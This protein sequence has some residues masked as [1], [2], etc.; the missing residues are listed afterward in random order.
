[1]KTTT[2]NH[3]AAA[4]FALLFSALS[5]PGAYS[6]GAYNALAA[7]AARASVP[8]P[9]PARA[10]GGPADH[11]KSFI[12]RDSVIITQQSA[13]ALAAASPDQRLQ[14]L[15]TLM[16]D[17]HP[18][19]NDPRHADRA[20]Q[21]VEQAILR[22]LAA[23]PDAASFDYVYYRVDHNQLDCSVTWRKDVENLVKKYSATAV[24]GDWAGLDRY[25]D[26]VTKAADSGRNLI[27]FLIDGKE[28][29]PVAKE[30]LEGAQSSIH[31][32]MYQLQADNIGQG[33]ADLLS[34]KAKA[35]LKVRLL[36]DRQGSSVNNDPAIVTML[37]GMQ[38]NGVSVIVKKQSFMNAHLDHRKI[39]VID[40][41]VGFTGGMNIG[42][43]YQVDW[44]DQQTLIKGPAVAR[45]QEAFMERWNTAGGGFGAGEDL[46]PPLVSYPDGYNTRV[47]GH[48]GHSD[49][50]LK[51]M[52]LR[53][54]STAQTSISIANPYLTDEDVIGALRA[55]ADRGVKV[56]L[57]LPQDND[58]PIVQHASRASYPK[59]VKAGVQVYE[60][61]GRMAHEKVAVFDGRWSTFGSSN[62]DERSLKNNDE[63]NLV[64]SDVRI[65]Q[66]IELRLFAADLPNC[67]LMN[68]YSPD[69]L[70]HMAQQVSSQL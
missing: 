61:K 18:G 58:I 57:V 48:I 7:G 17:S 65:G 53:A 60:Y 56:R 2:T 15:K 25:I 36:I 6:Q 21:E 29:I 16:N 10:A 68:T 69:V 5:V 41:K 22:V 67:E 20:Q 34:A 59:L 9:S 54:I 19:L 51:A 4:L 30:A 14:M 63:L 8:A 28:L 39:V 23:A 27:K 42:R 50:N 70:D 38:A 55:A 43:S 32:E 64:I 47:V 12:S 49:Q 45:L 26:T 24:P 35:G 1:M 40:G 33:L 62:L 13:Q 31:I 3:S 66:D 52:Y 37:D 11:D 44:H 46:F